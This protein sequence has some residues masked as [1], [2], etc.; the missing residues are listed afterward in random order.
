MKDLDVLTPL[1]HQYR[2]QSNGNTRK[3]LDNR[4]NTRIL[5]QTFDWRENATFSSR[6]FTESLQAVNPRER[7]YLEG[8]SNENVRL[9]NA[10]T[11]EHISI[12]MKWSLNCRKEKGTRLCWQELFFG[13]GSKSRRPD[14]LGRSS[15][16]SHQDTRRFQFYHP[17]SSSPKSITEHLISF[18]STCVMQGS[19]SLKTEMNCIPHSSSSNQQLQT[20]SKSFRNHTYQVDSHLFIQTI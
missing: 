19:V 10:R 5:K 14:M 6:A 12:K 3:Q 17:I 16:S 7:R 8:L 9:Q 2:S 15:S 11:I 1:R 4:E 20:T 18:L 13:K